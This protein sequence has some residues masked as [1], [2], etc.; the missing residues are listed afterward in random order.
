VKGNDE[1]KS[2]GKLLLAHRKSLV[3]SRYRLAKILG[4][5]ITTIFRWETNRFKLNT[6]KFVGIKHAIKE[7]INDRDEKQK[8]FQEECK[9]LKR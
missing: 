7:Y 5:N 9:K 4:T 6:H 8:D 2:N 1:P 3:L